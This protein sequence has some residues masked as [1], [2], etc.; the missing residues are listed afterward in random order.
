MRPYIGIPTDQLAGV[1]PYINTQSASV[2]PEAIK[3]AVIDAGGVPL[4]LPFP[5]HFDQVEPLIEADLEVVC[6][7]LLPGGPDLDPT[8]YGQEPELKLGSVILPE[9]RFELALTRRAI[10][11]GLP[12]FS[13]C[14]GMQ[15]LNVA[16]GG[17]LYQ[18]LGTDDPTARLRHAQAAPGQY[19]T[20]HVRM[21]KDSR[22]A[23]LIGET[24][25]VNSRHHQAVHHVGSTLRVSAT[26]PDG[27]IE[28]IESTASDQLLGVQWHPENLAEGDPRQG[29]LFKDLVMRATKFYH[30]H[31]R[32]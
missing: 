1:S 12:I 3:Q 7:L 16:C 25:Y 29:A 28:G 27:V 31:Q 24:A 30:T 9:D 15:L 21:A 26:A 10:Q 20:H 4:I 19:P 17:D 2:V 8:L 13:L 32:K 22:L 23:Q 6:G 11:A 5:E 14:R 18:D